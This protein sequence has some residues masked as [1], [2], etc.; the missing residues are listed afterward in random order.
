M[1]HA[2]RG[3]GTPEGQVTVTRDELKERFEELVNLAAG[4]KTILI[5][6]GDGIPKWAMV[7]PDFVGLSNGPE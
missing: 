6:D 7:P 4:G 3:T 5:T 1:Q 2:Q